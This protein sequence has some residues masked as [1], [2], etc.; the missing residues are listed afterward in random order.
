MGSEKIYFPFFQNSSSK[1]TIKKIESKFVKCLLL[2]IREIS[3]EIV[4]VKIV[5]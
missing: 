2:T 5:N 4:F 3:L 1:Y